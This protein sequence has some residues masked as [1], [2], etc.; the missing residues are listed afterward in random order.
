[1]KYLETRLSSLCTVRVTGQVHRLLGAV[2]ESRGLFAPIGGQCEIHGRGGQRLPAEVVGFRGEHAL[3]APFGDTRGLAAGDSIEYRGE[4]ARVRVSTALIGRVIDANGQPIDSVGQPL[5][6]G[7][8]VPLHRTAGNPLRRLPVDRVLPTGIRA[9]DAL[10]TVGRGQRLGIFAGSGVGKSVLLGMLARNTEAELVVLGLIGERSREVRE[11]VEGE[12][13]AGGLRRTVVVVATA[14]EPALKRLKAALVATAIAEYFRDRGR[15]VLLLLDSV[16]RV[17]LAQRELGLA[18]G[19]PPATRG[20]PPSVFEFLPRLL[21]RAGPGT[22]GSITAF[23]S[24]LVEVDDRSDPVIDCVRAALDG[25]LWLSRDLAEHGHF[26]AIDPLA[27]LSRVQPSLVDSR[28][29]EAAREVRAAL[30]RHQDA[31]EL[32][33]L[34]AY[35][36]GGD[37]RTDRAVDTKPAIDRFLRQERDEVAAFDETLSALDGLRAQ[38]EDERSEPTPT[39]GGP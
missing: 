27:S 16:S 29:L 1:M 9:I 15:H 28:R 30:A 22:R 13:G 31:A 26:P 14:E 21:E 8:D 33:R 23:F 6:R 7:V 32:I 19:E 25:H 20:Y 24:A 3:V 39:G 38:L 34:G 36:R 18:M 35:V 17:A 4:M 10:C 2:A 5:P 11:F 12:L 37:P